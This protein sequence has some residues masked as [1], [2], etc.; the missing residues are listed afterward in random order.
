MFLDGGVKLA[1]VLTRGASCDP[2]LLGHRGRNPGQ[3]KPGS[4]H[5][6]GRSSREDTHTPPQTPAQRGVVDG[7]G[8]PNGPTGPP[9][10]STDGNGP[11][12]T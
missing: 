4:S 7:R 6:N 8:P 9:D 12:T 5:P 2:P 11:I 3:H 10:G 1:D